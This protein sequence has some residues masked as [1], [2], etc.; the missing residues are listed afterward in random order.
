MENWNQQDTERENSDLQNDGSIAK[1]NE[2]W[3]SPTT[4]D[5]QDLEALSPSDKTAFYARN[6]EEQDDDNEDDDNEDEEDEEG[7]DEQTDWGDI[8]PASGPA[9]TSPG[10]AV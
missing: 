9:P 5:R 6:D 7:D 4:D 8:D 2:N 3:N 10:S 1:T